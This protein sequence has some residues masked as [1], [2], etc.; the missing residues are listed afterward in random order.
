MVRA[1]RGLEQ[2]RKENTAEDVLAARRLA[3]VQTEARS[4]TRPAAQEPM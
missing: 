3:V 2:G 4:R 1:G